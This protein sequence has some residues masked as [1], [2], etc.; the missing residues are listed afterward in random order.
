[1]GRGVRSVPLEEGVAE[2]ALGE[3]V[4]GLVEAVHVELPDEAVHL[5][6]PEE[7]RQNHLLELAH[8]LYHELASRRSPEYYLRELLGLRGEWLTLRIS[9]VLAMKPATSAG[10][11]SSIYCEL[12]D[13]NANNFKADPHS[14]ILRSRYLEGGAG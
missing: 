5:G 11:T 1:M 10:S 7:A 9:K 12:I 6:V 14:H 13:L 3:F 2:D 4:A 8:V